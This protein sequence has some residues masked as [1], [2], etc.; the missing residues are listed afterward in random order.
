MQPVLPWRRR[1]VVKNRNP[2][3]IRNGLL[4][5]ITLGIFIPRW[6]RV[7]IAHNIRHDIHRY[8]QLYLHCSLIYFCSFQLFLHSDQPLLEG[9]IIPF[10]VCQSGEAGH[11]RRRR[12]GFTHWL[13]VDCFD[14][15]TDDGSWQT[16]SRRASFSALASANSSHF[17]SECSNITLTHLHVS[18]CRVR[19]F[20]GIFV[21]LGFVGNGVITVMINSPWQWLTDN[22]KEIIAVTLLIHQSLWPFR[23]L[24][25]ILQSGCQPY[26][27]ILNQRPAV[28]FLILLQRSIAWRISPR[29]IIGKA[30]R[31]LI[32]CNATASWL[33]ERSLSVLLLAW[34]ISPTERSWVASGCLLIWVFGLATKFG[35]VTE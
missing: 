33:S 32:C 3:N 34:V 2:A 31:S 23:P 9:E 5:F 19:Q 18:N 14:V 1:N 26:A 22:Q 24:L 16:S 15:Q 27:R 13:T 21:A 28:S 11:S 30:P 4:G 35:R 10:S 6:K 20:S 25:W 7:C 8:G 17:A 12:C 29:S